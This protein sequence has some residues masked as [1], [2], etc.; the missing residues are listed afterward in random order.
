MQA[1]FVPLRW[2]LLPALLAAPAQAQS[3]GLSAEQG[4]P[5]WLSSWS[6]LS[7]R[8]DL[9]RRLPSSS[10]AIPI[11]LLAATPIGLFWTAGNPAG[12]AGSV[13]GARSDVLIGAGNT[14]GSFRRPLEPGGKDLRQISLTSWLPL[15][16]RVSMLGRIVLD[17]EGFSPGAQA[18]ETEPYPT[19]PF[20]TSDTSTT[21]SRRI[22][23]QL[24]GVAA[25]SFGDWALGADLAYDARENRTTAAG[26]VRYTRQTMPGLA[27]GVTKLLGTARIGLTARYRNRAETIRLTP[28]GDVGEVVQL[29]GYSEVAPIG[30]LTPYYRRIE[31]EVPSASLGVAGSLGAGRWVLFAETARLY[32][33]R[34]R[35]EQD[36]PAADRWNADSWT[37]GGSY[38]RTLG[39]AGRSRLTIDAR[40]TSVVGDGTL[41]LD[42]TGTVFTARER[43]FDAR[44]ELRRQPVSRGWSGLIAV[45]TRY[46]R[47]VRKDL[48]ALIGSDV[49]T[50]AY[51]VSLEAGRTLSPAWTVFGTAA[52]MH[53]ISNST[54]PEPRFQQAVYRRL[55]APEL[56]FYARDMTPYSIGAALKWEVSAR[57]GLW[58]SARTEAVKPSGRRPT[59]LGPDGSRTATAFVLGIVM[60]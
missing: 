30:L 51:G 8:A 55:I 6:V 53:S 31:E 44:V 23:T 26:F 60:K 58:L 20:V 28:R 36:D 40:F 12:L 38:Q 27:I 2:V 34:S 19:S 35:Q 33:R 48:V 25:W 57:T 10:T 1:R 47:R 11:S 18:D 16:R 5:A 50:L 29:E 3:L 54:L 43:A 46:E 13:D 7:P 32:E 15:D 39:L 42:T 17:Q 21:P 52:L 24:E 22:R 59:P 4:L 14:R 9:P 45:T 56:D 37:A 49:A 41:A